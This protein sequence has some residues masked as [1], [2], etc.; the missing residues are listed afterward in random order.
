LSG[1]GHAPTGQ[2]ADGG[3]TRAILLMITAMGGFVAGDAFI[4][5]AGRALPLGEIIVL[6]G[7]IATAIMLA[8]MSVLG[9]LSGFR[10]ALNLPVAVRTFGDIAATHLFFAALLVMPFADVI[11]IGQF[12]PLAVTAAAAIFL[13]EPVGWRR[14]L[15]TLVGFMGVLIIIRPGTSAF[16]WAAL[17]VL[18]C[19]AFI[20]VRDIVTRSIS[21]EVP[22]LMIALVTLIAVTVSGVVRGLFEVWVWPSVSVLWLMVGAAIGNCVGYYGIIAAMRTG[23]ISAVGPFRY[24]AILFGVVLGWLVFGEVPDVMT[25]LGIMIV[26]AAGLYTLHRERVRRLEGMQG[27][28]E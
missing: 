14:W 16:N 10:K 21:P 6:R 5:L 25:T 18:G 4:R 20:T 17:Y 3:T 11:S 28:A 12:T 19:V 15:A 26:V 13:A 8:V 9:S 1:T 24:S 22:S 27:S 7:A 2:V 23:D